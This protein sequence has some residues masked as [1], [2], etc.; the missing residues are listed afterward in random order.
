LQFLVLGRKKLEKERPMSVGNL[1]GRVRRGGFTLVELLTVVTI[2]AVLVGLVVGAMV[3]VKN[4]QSYQATRI[5]LEAL[6]GALQRYYEDFGKY[7]YYTT[8]TNNTNYGFIGTGNMP[9]PSSGTS[10][11]EDAAEAALYA[12]LTTTARKGPYITG[13]TQAV[14]KR[15]GAT[16]KYFIFTDGWGRKIRYTWDKASNAY[17]GANG[18]TVVPPRLTSDGPNEAITDDDVTNY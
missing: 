13:G 18:P 5:M 10:A 2:L 7:P 8:S 1:Y 17:P 6:D 11:T 9:F 15:V 14:L 4:A 12:A 16:I 3:G